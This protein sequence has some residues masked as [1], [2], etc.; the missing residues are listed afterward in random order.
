MSVADK[1]ASLKASLPSGVTLVAVSKTYPPSAIMEAYEAGQRVFGE[2]RPQE[3]AAKQAELP[4]DIEWHLIGGLQ[5]N[6]VKLVA[7]FVSM[8]HS[9]ESARL[10]RFIDREARRNDRV[11]D[12]LLEVRIAREES[13]H[14]W[15]EGEL[16]R[17]LRSGEYRSLESV[18]FRGLMG[19]AT[20]RTRKRSCVRNLRVFATCSS[21]GKANFSTNGSTRCRWACRPTILWPSNAAARWSA[22]AA[23]YSARGGTG[24]RPTM[25]DGS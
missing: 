2:N 24:H 4:G 13:K 9:A 20:N 5:T 17:Y 25:H 14:G 16:E 19:V 8:I 21:G 18:R 7:P 23:R 3:L 1:I 12:V 15:D 6:K 10:L 11:I 22:S